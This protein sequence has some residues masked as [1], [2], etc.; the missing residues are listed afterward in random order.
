MRPAGRKAPAS[1]RR[2]GRRRDRGK[3]SPVGGGGT[4]QRGSAGQR[5][6]GREGARREAGRPAK[7]G[8]RAMPPHPAEPCP[9][10][11][12]QP[13]A[14]QGPKRPICSRAPAEAHRAQAGAPQRVR[15]AVGGREANLAPRRAQPLEDPGRAGT[16][17]AAAGAQGA[18]AAGATGPERSEGCKSPLCPPLNRYRLVDREA[19]R[20]KRGERRPGCGAWGEKGASPRTAARRGWGVLTPR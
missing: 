15:A 11:P 9:P 17:T 20:G 7:A 3:G 2:A 12:A 10:H 1:D 19:G 18:P 4:A 5:T 16:T 8:P 13:F 14:R 6:E